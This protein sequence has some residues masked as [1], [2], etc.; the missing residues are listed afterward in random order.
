MAVNI[1]SS[2]LRISGISSGLDTDS[3]VKSLMKLSSCVLIRLCDRRPR[4]NGHVI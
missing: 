4:W 2:M 3:M 1:L